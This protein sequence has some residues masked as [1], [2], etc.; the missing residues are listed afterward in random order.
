MLALQGQQSEK[1]GLLEDQTLLPENK[2]FQRE[3]ALPR[4][5]NSS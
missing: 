4:M 3:C 2:P 5:E 1:T